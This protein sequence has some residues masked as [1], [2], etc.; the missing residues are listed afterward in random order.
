[1]IQIYGLWGTPPVTKYNLLGLCYREGGFW[2]LNMA[3][4][5]ISA[6][7]PQNGDEKHEK[8][9]IISNPEVT[10]SAFSVVDG[11]AELCYRS[12]DDSPSLVQRLRWKP[13]SALR[14]ENTT[15]LAFWGDGWYL[16][17]FAPR[18]SIPMFWPVELN[19]SHFDLSHYIHETTGERVL[20]LQRRLMAPQYSD[21]SSRPAFDRLMAVFRT[22][23]QTPYAVAFSHNHLQV[24]YY[25]DDFQTGES[26]D[27]PQDAFELPSQ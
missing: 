10:G 6:L 14:P 4:A 15:V 16:E 9:R 12:F 21:R 11:P 18:N 24:R 8:T 20:I 22:G 7:E 23:D 5:P 1:M 25:F 3:P 2:A 13:A 26:A 27:I 17:I 19:L